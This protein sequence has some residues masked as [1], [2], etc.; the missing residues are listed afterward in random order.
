MSFSTFLKFFGCALSFLAVQAQA[1]ERV[2]GLIEVFSFEGLVEVLDVDTGVQSLMTADTAIKSGT[3]LTTAG[4]SN[5]ILIFSNGSKL[6]IQPNTRL[7]IVAYEQAPVEILV[8]FAELAGDPSPS[9]TRLNL[10]YGE[11]IG[12]VNFLRPDSYYGISTPVG[13]A[14]IPMPN[15]HIVYRPDNNSGLVVETPGLELLVN[16]GI[17]GADVPAAATPATFV[18]QGPNEGP[19]ASPDRKVT[20]VIV[21]Q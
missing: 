3:T 13:N 8:P 14:E 12:A 19:L 9:V 11:L 21:S 7:E 10:E 5:V 20:A 4:N 1:D 17:P 18:S 15:Y 6:K 16:S 2:Y